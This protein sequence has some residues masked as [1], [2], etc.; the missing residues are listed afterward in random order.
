MVLY[1]RTVIKIC[2]VKLAFRERNFTFLFAIF[3]LKTRSVH[4]LEAVLVLRPECLDSD[5]RQQSVVT[6]EYSVRVTFAINVVVQIDNVIFQELPL[7]KVQ[8]DLINFLTKE[9]LR[10]GL[11]H[12][13]FVRYISCQYCREDLK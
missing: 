11:S 1:K 13:T 7:L 10:D 2:G 12:L 5:P 3:L 6:P 8:W 4:L 9:Y